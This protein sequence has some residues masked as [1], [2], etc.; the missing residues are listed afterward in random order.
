MAGFEINGK[1]FY[2]DGRLKQELDSKIIPLL[3]KK[4]K[5]VVFIVDGEERSGKSV[6][7][8]NIGGYVAQQLGTK[9]NNTNVCMTPDE[10]RH[11]I[12]NSDK[13]EVVIY[14]EAHR[15]MGSRRALSEINNILIDL[16]M[17]MGQ[18]NLFAIV[19]LPTFFMLDKY[20]ALYRAKGLFHIYER[21]GRRGFWVYY[22]QKKKLKLY[23]GGK[24]EFNYNCMKYPGFRGKFFDQYTIDEEGYRKKK[25][26]AFKE[27]K[28]DTK[29]SKESKYLNQRDKLIWILHK[30]VKIGSITLA[31]IMKEHDIELKHARLRE[32]LSEMRGVFDG[33]AI[34]NGKH[35][36]IPLRIPNFKGKTADATP[37]I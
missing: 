28:E 10:W 25:G 21:K 37:S 36:K 1:N 8:M 20:P 19:V 30:K 33:T 31:K 23:Q 2:I 15:G 12:E 5:D 7:S 34:T 6:F 32:I 9:F 22:N 14:D 18:R 4:D 3:K 24:K 29:I 11:K 26:E 13:N 16:M 17:E 27:R 35:S